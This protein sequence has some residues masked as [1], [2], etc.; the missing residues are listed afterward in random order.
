MGRV[1]VNTDVLETGAF[2]AGK[3]LPANYLAG[4]LSLSLEEETLLLFSETRGNRELLLK[5]VW[6]SFL[7]EQNCLV[8]LTLDNTFCL[9][10]C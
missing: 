5:L 3:E 9:T 4:R 2:P 7:S 6:M 10:A 8:L 1:F